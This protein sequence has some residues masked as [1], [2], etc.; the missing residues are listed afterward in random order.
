MKDTNVKE[1][2][3]TYQSKDFNEDTLVLIKNENVYMRA[4]AV[5]EILRELSFPWY[6]LRIFTVIPFPILDVVYTVFAK[7]RYKIFSK[8]SSCKIPKQ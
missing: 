3:H 1:G 8:K 4:E 2:I 6:L 7:N 5:L